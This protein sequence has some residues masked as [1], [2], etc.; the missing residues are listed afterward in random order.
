MN[1]KTNNLTTILL[2][3][4]TV[5]YI[6]CPLLIVICLLYGFYLILFRQ[7]YETPFG[8]IFLLIT[9]VV[10]AVLW[11]LDRLLVNSLHPL[12]LSAVELLMMSGLWLWFS[13]SNREFIID[14]TA[15]SGQTFI[16]AYTIDDT[17]AEKPDHVFPFGKKMTIT[18]RNYVILSEVYR[19][20]EKN[21]FSP[22]LKPSIRWKNGTIQTGMLVKER[23]SR[24][25]HLVIYLANDYQL[26]SLAEQKRVVET[27]KERV[28]KEFFARVN[29]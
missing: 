22:Y 11:G 12:A 26:L 24:F 17:I 13:Y 2:S 16:I 14:A 1:N 10:L 21:S 28:V 8:V 19:P 4:T 27:E 5:F 15:S 23:D 25:T 29:K 6:L 20:S 18:D 9:I 7:G 3:K